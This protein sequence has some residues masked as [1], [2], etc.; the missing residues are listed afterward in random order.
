MMI[1]KPGSPQEGEE[2]VLGTILKLRNSPTF[3]SY[4]CPRYFKRENGKVFK[5]E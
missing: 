3:P 5:P 2:L 4:H 1:E